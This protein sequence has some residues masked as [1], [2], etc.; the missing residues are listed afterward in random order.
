MA[1]S[2]ARELAEQGA[3]RLKEFSSRKIREGKPAA[4]SE[5]A[6]EVFVPCLQQF[7]REMA[8]RLEAQALSIDNDFERGQVE[9][10]NWARRL[11]LDAAGITEGRD[12]R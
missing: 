6:R 4:Q 10:R 11:I 12:D 3:L 2:R 9:G 1:S 8:E 5:V 7:A